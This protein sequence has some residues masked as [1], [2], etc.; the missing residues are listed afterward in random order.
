MLVVQYG[1]VGVIA[2]SVTLLFPF[3]CT[4]LFHLR[5]YVTNNDRVVSHSCNGVQEDMY[6]AS[7]LTREALLTPISILSS[8]TSIYCCTTVH[9]STHYFQRVGLGGERKRGGPLSVECKISNKHNLS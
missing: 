5:V 1:A 9:Y 6:W 4:R 3:H 8:P 2:I 7:L